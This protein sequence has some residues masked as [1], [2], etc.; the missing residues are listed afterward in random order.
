MS[1]YTTEIRFLVEMNSESSLPI[2]KRV[3][4][5]CPRIFNFDYPIW[6]LDY[7]KTLEKKI[8]MH[9]FTKEIGFETVGLWKL[10]LEER[11]NLIMPYYN[12]LY[13]TVS[14]KYDWLE[15]INL[16]ENYTGDKNTK[17]NS[18]ENMKMNLT[19]NAT[20]DA[21]TDITDK[22]TNV[23]DGLSS[24]TGKDTTDSTLA[25]NKKET[26][27]KKSSDLKSD[28]PQANYQGLDYGT[29]L[30]EGT[31]N[32]EVT[33]TNNSTSHSTVDH[34]NTVTTKNTTSNDNTRTDNT[35]AHVNKTA[36][37]ENNTNAESTSLTNDLFTR[38]TKGLNGSRSKTQLN[39]EYRES[40]INI[41]KM[42]IE[43]LKDLF[44][45]IY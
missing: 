5:A 24:D 10:Y 28:L 41:D 13:T 1:K 42:V 11:M 17:I 30:N 18:N 34:S 29:E 43:E 32:S 37:N 19:E 15:D 22:T 2:T 8:L 6:S 9:Y 31:G 12:D 44:M 45:M 14:N 27:T 23:L 25:E 38:I 33:G 3:E 7:K 26:T 36:N 40:L 16:N 39:V 21:K 4:Q 20:N 35:L